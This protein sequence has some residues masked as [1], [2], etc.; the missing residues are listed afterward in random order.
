MFGSR[1]P[2]FAKVASSYNNNCACF[3]LQGVG[4]NMLAPCWRCLSHDSNAGKWPT[5]VAGAETLLGL[6]R[7]IVCQFGCRVS[8]SSV[9]SPSFY[10]P[11]ARVSISI[12]QDILNRM[13]H[14]VLSPT[15]FPPSGSEG[16]AT[17]WLLRTRG[18]APF[19]LARFPRN[20]VP[21]NV[22]QTRPLH[23][24]DN[25]ASLFSR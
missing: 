21:C 8:P 6:F 24:E 19:P 20:C 7:N 17:L 13:L 5:Q 14:G 10:R 18:S 16:T 9:Q 1:L 15:V 22:I 2:M 23:S 4:V 12:A 3:V 25:D 11:C